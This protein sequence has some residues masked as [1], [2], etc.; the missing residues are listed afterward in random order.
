MNFTILEHQI[1]E[2]NIPINPIRKMLMAPSYKPF[3]IFKKFYFIRWKD[4][5]YQ[6][7]FW[8]PQ[9]VD[10]LISEGLCQNDVDA[11]SQGQKLLE[12]GVIRHVSQKHHF[13]DAPYLYQ[14]G[15]RN[16]TVTN[17]CVKF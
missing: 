16:R 8:G 10:W 11:E 4:N 9:L 1:E 5:V 12:G 7:S 3:S 15:K 14:F 6:D 2:E 13:Y 17:I